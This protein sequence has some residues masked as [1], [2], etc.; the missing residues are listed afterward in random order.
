MSTK[1]YPSNPDALITKNRVNLMVTGNET[2][3]TLPS[4]DIRLGFI[5]G[6]IEALQ[7]EGT[8]TV[9]PQ[10]SIDDGTDG[11]TA[12]GVLTLT[13][14]ATD[15]LFNFAAATQGYVITGSRTIRLRKNVLGVGQATTFRARADGVA[16][17]TTGAAHGF[18]VGDEITVA[19][20]GGSDYNGVWFV[21]SVPTSTTFTYDNPLGANENSTADTAG[22]VGAYWALV[23]SVWA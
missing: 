12:T 14:G 20:V 11:E 16:T 10:V 4:S 19:S 8:L 15:R 3:F 2:I 17:L 18:S 1:F 13:S 7:V 5:A 9:A 6:Y 21:K 22:R 23:T